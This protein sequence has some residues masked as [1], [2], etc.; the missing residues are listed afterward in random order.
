MEIIESCGRLWQKH[1]LRD[2]MSIHENKQ[3][4]VDFLV[5]QWIRIRPCQCRG[6]GVN[7]LVWEDSSHRATNPVHHNYWVGVL[8]EPMPARRNPLQYE[9]HALQWRV[10]RLPQLVQSKMNELQKIIIW[11]IL[12][13]PC[14]IFL[15][16]SS[17]TMQNVLHICLVYCLSPHENI[18]PLWGMKFVS[19]V[20]ISPAPE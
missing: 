3:S 12:T 13:S 20:A 9:A 10:A 17:I 1:V 15:C 16:L 8:L 2:R 7:P 5:V 4:S 18:S 14:L 19:L 11:H 6:R